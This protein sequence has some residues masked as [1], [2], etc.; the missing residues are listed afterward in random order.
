LGF[1]FGGS[2]LTT[3]LLFSPRSKDQA[4]IE[5]AY[6]QIKSLTNK[7]GVPAVEW[8]I[9]KLQS[10]WYPTPEIF[11]SL[12]WVQDA[13]KTFGTLAFIPV[14]DPS[15]E[16]HLDQLEVMKSFDETNYT[17]SWEI[18]LRSTD[19]LI[20][21]LLDY[22]QNEAEIA[23]AGTFY[24]IGDFIQPEHGHMFD[25]KNYTLPDDIRVNNSVYTFQDK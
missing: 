10:V 23:T 18:E 19:G 5:P 1:D 11:E 20:Q 24:A 17:I 13:F 12:D 14:F 25:T 8:C 22:S 9:F 15:Y 4:A 21:N 6:Y 2:F 7:A 16:S 3:H